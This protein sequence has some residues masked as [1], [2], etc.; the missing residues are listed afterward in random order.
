MKPTKTK[1]KKHGKARMAHLHTPR[2]VLDRACA[3]CHLDN[4]A[5]MDNWC[6]KCPNKKHYLKNMKKEKKS[7]GK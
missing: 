7:D 2:I 6:P 4:R 1:T 5:W 3:I